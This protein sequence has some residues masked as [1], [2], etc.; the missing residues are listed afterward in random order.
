MLLPIEHY[1]K[2]RENYSYND[3][4]VCFTL[5]CV[6]F[7]DEKYC[8]KTWKGIYSNIRESPDSQSI[9][10]QCFSD[11]VQAVFVSCD[12]ATANGRFTND[13][14][15]NLKEISSAI[16]HWK[17]SSQRGRTNIRVNGMLKKWNAGTCVQLINGFRKQSIHDF[18]I[19]G[20]RIPTA[21]TFLRFIYPESFGIIGSRVVRLTQTNNI[22]TMSIRG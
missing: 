17:M 15:S 4:S 21:S 18:C 12:L 13:H 1:I 2:N 14:E 3:E 11:I 8:N 5:K 9:T 22:T 10:I 7:L 19:G 16:V 20:V 6:E